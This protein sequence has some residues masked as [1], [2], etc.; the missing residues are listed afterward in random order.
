M[1]GRSA[2]RTRGS[3]V[4]VEDDVHIREAMAST[5]TFEGY[6]VRTFGSG[7]AVA[8][9]IPFLLRP[10]GVILDLT[11]SDMSGGQCLHLIRESHWGDVPVL[12]H[13]GWGHLD[14]FGLDAQAVLSKTCDIELVARAVDRLT[15]GTRDRTAAKGPV[16]SRRGYVPRS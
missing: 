11:L 7:K 3:V 1:R 5:L 10:A 6:D 8:G 13:S 4:I 16:R 9:G 14:R 12:I 15:R 2:V